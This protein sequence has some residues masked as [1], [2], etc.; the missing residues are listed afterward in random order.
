[1]SILRDTFCPSQSGEELVFIDDISFFRSRVIFLGCCLFKCSFYSLHFF[2]SCLIGRSMF[3]KASNCFFYVIVLLINFLS[4]F[5]H[6]CYVSSFNC[7]KIACL[8][9]HWVG[10]LYYLWS[11]FMLDLN[12]ACVCQ[13]CFYTMDITSK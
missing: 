13:L 1:M 12:I 4:H 8:W 11:F 10:L 2:L 3:S 7:N 6:C 9:N 5:M